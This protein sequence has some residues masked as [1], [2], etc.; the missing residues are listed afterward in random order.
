MRTFG[1]RITG[2]AALL[3]KLTGIQR[4]VQGMGLPQVVAVFGENGG[5]DDSALVGPSDCNGLT[6]CEVNSDC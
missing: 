5:V 4:P 1:I 3:S 2:I 6:K